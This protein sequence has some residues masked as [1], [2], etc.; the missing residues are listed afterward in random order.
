[1]ALSR[2]YYA[3]KCNNQLYNGYIA[4]LDE[5]LK[6]YDAILG[7]QKYLAGNVSAK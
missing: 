2:F 3:T 6:A 5:R 4:N 1:M 7:R